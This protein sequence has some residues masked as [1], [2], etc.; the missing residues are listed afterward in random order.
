ML[1]IIILVF[2]LTIHTHCTQ[3]PMGTFKI[4]TRLTSKKR[5]AEQLTRQTRNITPSFGR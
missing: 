2:R 5:I 1:D 3:R 4:I